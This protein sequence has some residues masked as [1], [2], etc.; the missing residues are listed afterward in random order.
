MVADGGY[1]HFIIDEISQCRN[2]PLEDN[3]PHSAEFLFSKEIS[4]APDN[5]LPADYDMQLT[6][7]ISKDHFQLNSNKYA[8]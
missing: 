5:L 4:E 1:L 8:R 7:L 2:T 6:N 3:Y